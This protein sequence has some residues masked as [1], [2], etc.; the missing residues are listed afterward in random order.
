M[1]VESWSLG[2]RTVLPNTGA[3]PATPSTQR[4]NMPE[5]LQ[6]RRQERL[7]PGAIFTVRDWC[8]PLWETQGMREAML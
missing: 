8:R 2:K 5:C 7:I 4:R 6:V 1:L 3:E